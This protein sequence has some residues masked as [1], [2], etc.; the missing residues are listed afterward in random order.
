[1]QGA[2]KSGDEVMLTSGIFGRLVAT[3]DDHVRVEVA[4]G[5]TLKVARGAIASVVRQELVADEPEES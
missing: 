5:V 2:L 1:M 4:D 3:E